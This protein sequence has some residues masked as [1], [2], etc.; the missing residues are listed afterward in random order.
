MSRVT[1]PSGCALSSRRP[2][3]GASSSG[4]RRGAWRSTARPVRD[5][6][7]TLARGRR[8][9]ARPRAAGRAAARAASRS[10][11]RT[12][13]SSSCRQAARPPHDRHRARARPHRLPHPVGLPGGQRRQRRPFIVHRLDRDTSGLIVFAKSQGKRRLQAQFEARSVERVYLALVEGVRARRRG[14]P[15]RARLAEDRIL[16]VRSARPPPRG[17]AAR[18]AITHYRVLRAA[19]RRR[20]LELRARHRP[21]ASDPRAARRDRA[22]DRRRRQP[23][24]RRPGAAPGRALPARHAARLR[25]PTADRCAGPGRPSRA[26]PPAD[27]V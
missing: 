27:W 11:T 1:L 13:R 17:A 16:R 2:R 20:L 26:A 12:T 15:S 4:S 10:C 6:R 23:T 21:A 3:A 18:E 14:A 22:S 19:A 8:R 24:G 5:G 25:H 9:R 7:L